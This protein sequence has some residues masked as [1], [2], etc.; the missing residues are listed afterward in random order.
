[1]ITS[2]KDLVP[3]DKWGYRI[4]IVEAFRRRGIYPRNVRTLSPDALL[5]EWP[6][7][8]F[9]SVE[10]LVRNLDLGW[11]LVGDRRAIYE[12]NKQNH[13]VTHAW[14]TNLCANERDQAILGIAMAGKRGEI[15][16]LY[17]DSF[18]DMPS[19]EIHSVRPARRIGPNGDSRDRSRDRDHPAAPRVHG[20]DG[21]RCRR[22]QPA[23]LR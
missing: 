12:R 22:P 2:D 13:V 1:M 8:S 18:N 21:A 4:A 10:G 20:S 5:W 11:D 14:L 16:S 15:R 9:S 19:V 7:L 17:R 23:V 6:D 3:D